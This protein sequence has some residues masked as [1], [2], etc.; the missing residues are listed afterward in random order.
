MLFFAKTPAPVVHPARGDLLDLILVV[1]A[2]LYAVRGYRRGVILGILSFG[3]WLA[4]AGVGALLAP[5]IARVFFHTNLNATH[6]LGQRVLGLA[7]VIVFSIIGEYFGVL[8]GLR[9]RRAA[10]ATPLRIFDSIGGAALS[11]AGLLVVAWLVATPLSAAPF[12]KIA[13]Q[14]KHSAILAAVD[15]VMPSVISTAFSDL[16]RLFQQHGFPRVF[17]PFSGN[18]LPALVVPAPNAGVVPPT[19][20]KAGPEVVKIT[21]LAESC[22]LEVEGSGFVYAPQHVMTNAHVV[23]GVRSPRVTLPA[24]GAATLAARVVLY[25]PD[26]DIAIL[27]VPALRRPPLRFDGTMKTRADGVV[28]GY[29]ENGPLK[30]VPARVAGEQEVTGPNIYG[31]KEVTRDVYTLRADVRHGN[32]G[33]PLLTTSGE[34][35]GVIFA[36]NAEVPNVGYALTHREVSSDARAGAHRTSAVSTQGCD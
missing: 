16:A 23:A 25:D 31:N 21:G 6:S 1:V 10:F 17:N 9:F 36:A 24:P 12:P 14:I 3:G 35:G 30:A 26:R 33:G 8:I 4:G 32:S 27:Y 7:V 18:P 34:V 29:P 20:R 13:R 15:R 5:R 11:V 2:L 19:I 28:A 22:S